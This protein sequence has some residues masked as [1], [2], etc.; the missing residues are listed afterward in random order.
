MVAL[1]TAVTM[2]ISIKGYSVYV[3]ACT[4][5][6]ITTPPRATIIARDERNSKNV[7]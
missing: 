4:I 3:K 7:A 1:T 5:R 2:V 6:E